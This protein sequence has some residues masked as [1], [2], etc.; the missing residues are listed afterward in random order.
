MYP[1]MAAC[2]FVRTK[3]ILTP[4]PKH[5]H[6]ISPVFEAMVPSSSSSLL[7]DTTIDPSTDPTALPCPNLTSLALGEFIS[8]AAFAALNR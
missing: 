8:P 1:W 6:Q 5:T 3:S 7:L 4:K 2:V